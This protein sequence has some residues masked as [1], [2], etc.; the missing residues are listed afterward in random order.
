M[1]EQ[2]DFATNIDNKLTQ[3]PPISLI[4]KLITKK[5]RNVVLILFLSLSL[6][7]EGTRFIGSL[8]T[9]PLQA[10]DLST[11]DGLNQAAL[12]FSKNPYLV[13]Q[14]L[15]HFT[16]NTD[17]GII[18]AKDSKLSLGFQPNGIGD[19]IIANINEEISA[20]N[21]FSITTISNSEVEKI[22]IFDDLP[23]QLVVKNSQ[24]YSI[25]VNTLTEIFGAAGVSVT[26]ESPNLL[27]SERIELVNAEAFGYITI[28]SDDQ[29]FQ[30]GFN[31]NPTSITALSS[32]SNFPQLRF[33]ADHSE[34]DI[35]HSN[36]EKLYNTVNNSQ[37]SS[38]P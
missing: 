36:F 11:F 18:S 4:D 24:Q 35:V 28:K 31:N 8:M 16:E 27:V 12:E 34:F 32:K 33:T 21:P 1:N 15:L 7:I 13:R 3:F 14:L 30:I 19:P 26:L 37:A 25:I 10:L 22:D 17:S 20:K 5:L 38:K 6:T 23:S 2:P 9:N 29:I